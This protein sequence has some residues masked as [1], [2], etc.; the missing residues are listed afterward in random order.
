MDLQKPREQVADAELLNQIASYN[1]ET[2]AALR[3]NLSTH[4]ITDFILRLRKKFGN[5]GI[6]ANIDE[7]LQPDGFDWSALGKLTLDCMSMAPGASTM[8]GLFD[9]K[10]KQRKQPIKRRKREKPRAAVN[11]DQML[12]TNQENMKKET[13]ANIETMFNILR[14]FRQPIMASRL[15]NN[16]RSFSQTVENVFSL[17]FLVKDGR[18]ELTVDPEGRI[19]AAPKNAPTAADLAAGK[20]AMSQFILRLDYEDWE[21]MQERLEN[22]DDL[23]P[24][25]EVESQP[26]RQEEVASTP[27]RGG[28][29]SSRKTTR[30][31]LCENA[32]NVEDCSSTAPEAQD[33][34]DAEDDELRWS[35]GKRRRTVA[36]PLISKLETSASAV[37]YT[38]CAEYGDRIEFRI[39]HVAM[40]H[41]Q[42][43]KRLVDNSYT[44]LATVSKGFHLRLTWCRERGGDGHKPPV[45]LEHLAVEQCPTDHE[46]NHLN[47]RP[48]TGLAR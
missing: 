23:M 41:Q 25:R 16:R 42:Y 10:P 37:F 5:A 18:V 38:P 9:C 12:E 19:W 48:K 44:D 2:A 31:R 6:P 26:Q 35:G 30:N 33:S 21:D 14:R 11:P 7:P 32:L 1:Y 29:G 40:P 28:P 4:S 8:V 36:R 43:V 47:E 20:A 15:I 3:R 27:H 46:Q 22:E 24:H 45:M 17:S 39:S 34:A 13:D